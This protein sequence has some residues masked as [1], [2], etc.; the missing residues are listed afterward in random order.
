MP[1]IL[2]EPAHQYHANPATGSTSAK[3][4]R[5]SLRLYRDQLDGLIPR[6]EKPCWQVGTIVHLRTLE[7]ERYALTTRSQGPINA[8][9]GKPYGRDSN[10]FADWQAANPAIIMVEPFIDAMCARMP[11]HV[12]D[13]LSSGVAEATVRVAYDDRLTVQCRPDWMRGGDDW[14]L[15]TIDDVDAWERQVR[16]FDYWF[17]AGWYKM[18]KRL[19]GLPDGQWRWIFAEKK[20][21]YRWRVVRMSAAYLLRAEEEAERIVALISGA[22]KSGDWDDEDE[23]EIVAELPMH[24]DEQEVTINQE[25]GF[26]L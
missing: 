9:T 6:E 5:K 22:M 23:G 12:R 19:A 17:S 3:L 21:P 7:P 14:D 24:L 26:D 2:G 10:A 15:K 1:I 20:P 13:V 18:V 25:G 16:S 11:A 4:A 8:K